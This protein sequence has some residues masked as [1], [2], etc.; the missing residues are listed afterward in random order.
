MRKTLCLFLMMSFG[1]VQAAEPEQPTPRRTDGISL[2]QL[3]ER[4][5]ARLNKRFIVDPRV[6][7][8]A[9]L[10]GIDPEK[11]SYRELQA[12]LSVHGF[13]TTQ[14]RN[15]VIEIIPDAI[16]RQVPTPLI[17]DRAAN[18]GDDEYV[19]RAMEAGTLEAGKLVPILRPLLPQQA[20]MVADGQTNTLIVVASYA[21]VRRIESIVNELKKRPIV[22]PAA[23]KTAASGQ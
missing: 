8:E 11:I 14:E 2:T 10:V 3:I 15:G 7:G 20:H 16:A 4:S 5:A 21:D 12:V 6:R 17:G 23:P 9:I 22:A 19:T 1:I 18:V 13:I